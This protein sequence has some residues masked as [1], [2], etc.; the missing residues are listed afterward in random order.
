MKFLLSII[1]IGSVGH[2]VF[3]SGKVLKES[4]VEKVLSLELFSSESCSSCPVA[5][6]WFGNLKSDKKV[7]VDYVPMVFHV[8]YWNYLSWKDKYSSGRMTDRQVAYASRWPKRNV[9]TPGVI[10]DGQEWRDWKDKKKPEIASLRRPKVGTLTLSKLDG[11]KFSLKFKP[12]KKPEAPLTAH[13]A[14]LGFDL[15]T[16]VTAGENEGKTLQH[17]FVVLDWFMKKLND[18]NE[19]AFKVKLEKYK[20]QKIAF[21]AWVNQGSNPTPMQILGDYF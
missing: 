16:K 12:I 7:F 4:P 9:Y 19:A 18:E 2:S 17:N 6:K 15:S 5:D 14:I 1:L 3:A 11:S 20:D 21:A 8:D 10:L 13:M